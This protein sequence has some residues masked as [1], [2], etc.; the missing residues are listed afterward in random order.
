MRRR[1]EYNFYVYIMANK[2]RT[3]YIGVTNDLERRA[4]E[5][6]TKAT[7]GFTAKYR[8]DQLVYFEH[9]DDI[10]DAIAREKQIK[11][12]TRKKKIALVES[13]NPEWKDLAADWYSDV[14]RS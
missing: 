3:I 2:W 5:H 13:K 9:T 7:P 11:G 12:W 10:R 14:L 8:L 6:K 1:L 4:W